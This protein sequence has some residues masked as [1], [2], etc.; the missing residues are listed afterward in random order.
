MFA[1]H[2]WSPPL[3]NLPHFKS[4]SSNINSLKSSHFPTSA[5]APQPSPWHSLVSSPSPLSIFVPLINNQSA[6]AKARGPHTICHHWEG[7]REERQRDGFKR[8]KN[9][10]E[11]G[12]R[13]QSISIYLHPWSGPL[14]WYRS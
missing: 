10:E 1:V 7:K 13:V 14:R 2:P 8:K 5:A 4:L 11:E 3:S 9:R 12:D 6:R